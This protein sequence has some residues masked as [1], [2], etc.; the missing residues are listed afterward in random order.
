MSSIDW[1]RMPVQ[2]YRSGGMYYVLAEG[3]DSTQSP[4]A[5][6]MYV[7]RPL[8][9]WQ[10]T[11]DIAGLGIE[12]ITAEASTV[13]RLGVWAEEELEGGFPGKLVL[14]AGVTGMAGTSM[15]RKDNTLAT[16]LRLVGPARYYFSV[17]VQGGAGTLEVKMTSGYTPDAAGQYSDLTN[18]FSGGYKAS[19][20]TT[21]ALPASFPGTPSSS[22]TPK[23][24]FWTK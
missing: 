23:I 7:A 1:R 5:N 10:P 17:C 2:K 21:G 11:L 16:P 13:L 24:Y 6:T 8:D 20:T 22:R 9:L 12:V 19:T 14:D 4:V 18:L 3:G 15:G